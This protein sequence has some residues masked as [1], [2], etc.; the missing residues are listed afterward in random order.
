MARTAVV[1]GVLVLGLGFLGGAGYVWV[2]NDLAHYGQATYAITGMEGSDLEPTS[3]VRENA[4]VIA[5]SD[6][7]PKAQRAF[8]RARHGRENTLW[9]KDDRRA[10]EALLPY[11]TEYI[12]YQGAYYRI[13][14]LSGHRG[15][16]YWWRGL[17]TFV[18]SGGVGL[19]LIGFGVRERLGA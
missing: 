9:S 11:S 13:L 7:P 14:I 19:A 8:D 17:L 5:Y 12:E 18:G 10:V 16:R 6:L 4:S 15:Q 2:E 3:T 1:I